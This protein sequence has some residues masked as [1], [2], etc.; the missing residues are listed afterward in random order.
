[1]WGAM[2]VIV[3]IEMVAACSIGLFLGFI[4]KATFSAARI[5]WSQER[6]LREAARARE[7]ADWQPDPYEQPDPYD[8]LTV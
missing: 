4:L 6:V 1:M 2:A 5:S 8:R 7:N 3:L